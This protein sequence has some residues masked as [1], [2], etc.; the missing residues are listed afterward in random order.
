MSDRF[1]ALVC[2]AVVCGAVAF[3]VGTADAR[4]ANSTAYCLQG[5][6]ANGQKVRAGSVAMNGVPLGTKITVRSSPTGRKHWVV[7]D[8]IGHGTQLDFWVPTC[9]QAIRWGRRNVRW[10]FGWW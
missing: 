1:M 7:R 10:G 4:V 6:M 8:R 3:I 2:L 9:G 5:T